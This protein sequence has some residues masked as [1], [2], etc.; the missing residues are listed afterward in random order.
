MASLKFLKR[1]REGY[2]HRG[3]HTNMHNKRNISREDFISCPC[4]MVYGVPIYSNMSRDAQTCHVTSCLTLL[5]VLKTNA[6]AILGQYLLQTW[7]EVKNWVVRY[8]SI[9]SAFCNLRLKYCTVNKND[10]LRLRDHNMFLGNI[11][12]CFYSAYK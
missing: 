4:S 7:P 9:A 8:H 12:E 1:T 2:F 10:F 11:K 5:I 6:A 3:R